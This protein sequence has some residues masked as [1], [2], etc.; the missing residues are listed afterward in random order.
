MSFFR[1]TEQENVMNETVCRWKKGKKD[2]FIEL[3]I[4]RR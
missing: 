1:L 3:M 2:V 4:V